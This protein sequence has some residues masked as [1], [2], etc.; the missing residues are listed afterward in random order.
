MVTIDNEVMR[1][2]LSAWRQARGLTQ[3]K[4]AERIGVSGPT[5]VRMEKDP[6]RISI[7][8]ANKIA[9]VLGIAFENIIFLPNN[10]TKRTAE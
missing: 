6:T 1:L 9:E 8:K 3:E 5:Y 4:M 10:D 7:G 2:P